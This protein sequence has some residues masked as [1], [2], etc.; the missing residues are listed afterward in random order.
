MSELRARIEEAVSTIRQRCASAP[1]IGIIL[2]TG[3]GQLADRIQVEASIDYA[4]I[5]GFVKP[6][7]ESHG[8][9]L[10]FGRLAGA[11][12]VAMKGRFHLYEG[13]SQAEI[14]FPVRVLKALGAEVLIVSNACGGLNPQWH[15]GDLMIIEDHINFVGLSGNNP[16][17]GPN[18]EAL[19]VRFPDMCEPYDKTLVN[20]ARTVALKHN[21]VAHTGVYVAVAGPYLETR[22]EYRMLRNFGA[23]VVGMST[24]HEVTVAV[25]AGMRVLG[26]S[27]ITDECLPD[28]LKPVNIER[29]L[30]VAAQ[31]EP[32]LTALIENV[33][34]TMA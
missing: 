34:K 14:T 7:V 13:Y 8:G 28:A 4:D 26:V 10:I 24:V 5:P 3:L 9:Q 19:G 6:T 33:V 11:Q 17:V 1:Q 18:D 12:V 21:I 29:I 32:Q 30:A 15:A 2:G 31:A 16:L 22:A 25:H 20:L 27:V 23:D